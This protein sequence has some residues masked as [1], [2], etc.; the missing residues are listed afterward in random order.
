[1]QL[2]TRFVFLLFSFSLSLSSVWTKGYIL[3]PKVNF[4]SS[5]FD[6]SKLVADFGLEEIAS[7]EFESGLLPVYTSN[8]GALLSSRHQLSVYFDIEEDLEIRLDSVDQQ[9]V[10]DSSVQE[11]RDSEG[12]SGDAWHLSRVTSRNPVDT[13]SFPYN[14]AGSCHRN[15]D[16]VINTYIVDTGIDVTHPQFEGRA[17][18]GSNFVD[19][20]DTD[21]NKHGTHVAG[22][23]GSKDYGVCVDANLFAVKVLNCGGSGSLSGVIKGIEW[24]FKKHTNDSVKYSNKTVK[25]VI[26]MSLGGGYSAALNKVVERCAGEK[27]FYIVVAA[28]NENADACRGS[29]AGVSSVLT[30]MASDIDDNRAWFSNWGECANMYGPGVNVLSTVPGGGTEELSGTSMASPV[31]TGVLLHYLDMYPKKNMAGITKTMLKKSTKDVIKGNK[32]KTT[33]ALVYLR[34]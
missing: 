31:V 5:T 19:S 30:V 3:T 13:H 16:L 26:N 33:N 32:Q 34:R 4:V 10:F 27:N 11:Q 22:L 14:S 9:F 8:H 7:F 12:H 25:S 6:F 17:Q 28:G 24:V 20:Q 21:C 29:P 18:W 23:V 1:M 15:G 2:F